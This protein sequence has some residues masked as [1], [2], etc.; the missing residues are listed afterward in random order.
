MALINSLAVINWFL[1][2]KSILSH[3]TDKLRNIVNIGREHCR[4]K[5]QNFVNV[6]SI[7]RGRRQSKTL[8]TID[9]RGSKID[10]TVFLIVAIE[11][12]NTIEER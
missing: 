6:K 7:T 10:R 2:L 4:C 8:S 1:S 5:T 12:A 9:E 11:N 3:K